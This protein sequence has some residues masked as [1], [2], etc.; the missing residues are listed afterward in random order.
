MLVEKKAWQHI[1]SFKGD[2]NN[3]PKYDKIDE[4]YNFYVDFGPNT[5]CNVIGTGDCDNNVG[6][7]VHSA[8]ICLERDK[9]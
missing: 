4:L 3:A 2:E 7:N 1:C 8:Y 5:V 6:Y 9:Y